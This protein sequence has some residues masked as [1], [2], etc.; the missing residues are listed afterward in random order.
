MLFRGE[1]RMM[2]TANWKSVYVPV[3]LLVLVCIGCW[4][5]SAAP[6]TRKRVI[7]K[8]LPKICSIEDQ[9]KNGTDDHPPR[10]RYGTAEELYAANML[11][12]TTKKAP[13]IGYDIKILVNRPNDTGTHQEAKFYV[14]AIPPHREGY[15]PEV[16][17]M[18]QARQ[19]WGIP[20]D[21]RSPEIQNMSFAEFH[22]FVA[23]LSDSCRITAVRNIN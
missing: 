15:L 3:F 17:C 10:G 8:I 21:D 7:L 5:H 23:G 20:F 6:R 16:Y 9:Y 13:F 1:V 14:I 2:C 19:A 4:D 18:N 22:S 11:V 12:S